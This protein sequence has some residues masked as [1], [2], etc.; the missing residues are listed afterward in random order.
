[1][2]SRYNQ[3]TGRDY[4]I[5]SEEI[6]QIVSVDL[7]YVKHQ[8]PGAV[9]EERL[10]TITSTLRTEPEMLTEEDRQSIKNYIDI[11][12]SR[13]DFRNGKRKSK[14]KNCEVLL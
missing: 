4:F 11:I 14:L 6:R 7:H 3:I 1:M 10:R 9:L 13:R 12:A 2:N 8:V 5:N